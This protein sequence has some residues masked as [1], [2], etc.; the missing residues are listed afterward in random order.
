MKGEK[1]KNKAHEKQISERESFKLRRRR[2][3][4]AACSAMNYLS[5]PGHFRMERKEN[6][7][8][9]TSNSANT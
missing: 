7:L 9:S 4:S 1:E 3:Y 8:A 2:I 6:I 5:F